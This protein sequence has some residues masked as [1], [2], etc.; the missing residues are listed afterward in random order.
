MRTP[1]HQAT[2]LLA[3]A[4]NRFSLVAPAVETGTALQRSASQDIAPVPVRTALACVRR[5][6]Q[7]GPIVGCVGV[8]AVHTMRRCA[9]QDTPAVPKSESIRIY[10]ESLRPDMPYKTVFVTSVTTCEEVV[11]LVLRKYQFT[12]DPSPYGL[13]RVRDHAGT[14]AQRESR[15]AA[16]WRA[17]R[18]RLTRR[19]QWDGCG[20]HAHGTRAD[21]RRGDDA[22]GAADQSHGQLAKLGRGIADHGASTPGKIGACATCPASAWIAS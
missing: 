12:G 10:A 9:A 6:V 3:D 15:L 8:A 4:M 18:R 11:A 5:I 1:L 20:G 2:D 21:S 13:Y 19:Q 14:R 7:R 22:V 17:W 16:G